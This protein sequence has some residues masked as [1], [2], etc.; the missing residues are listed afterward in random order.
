M[1]YISFICNISSCFHLSHISFTSHISHCN[2]HV[3]FICHMSPSSVTYLLHMS[4]VSLIFHTSPSPV[5]SFLH[6]W[7]ISFIWN[8]LYI[9]YMWHISFI[10]HRYSL[11]VPASLTWHT[12]PLNTTN[13]FHL[14]EACFKSHILPS[15]ISCL[16]HMSSNSCHISLLSLSFILKL[17]H[18]LYYCTLLHTAHQCCSTTLHTV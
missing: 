13:L 9:L 8:I 10:C 12:S 15:L 1:S 2:S 14:S 17:F 5:I 6:L 11:L 16:P 18:S 7:K 4:H 3:S